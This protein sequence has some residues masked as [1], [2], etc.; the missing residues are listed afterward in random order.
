MAEKCLIY[1]ARKKLGATPGL[2]AVLI[3][4]SDYAN[5]SAPDEDPGDGLLAMQKLESSALSAWKVA[6]QL[7]ALDK[8][9][10]LLRPLKTVRLLIAPSPVEVAVEPKL[11]KSK[12]ETPTFEAIKAALK[13]WRDDVA[14]SQS[15]QAL[16]LFSG[17][18]LRRMVQDS[19]LLASD[20]LE[21]EDEELGKAFTLANVFNGMMPTGKFLEI[22]REQVYLVDACRDKPAQLDIMD[23]TNTPKIFGIRLNDD[24][25][26][27]RAAPIIFATMPGGSAAG[28]SGEPTYFAQSLLWALENGT[29]ELQQIDGPDGEVWPVSIDSLFD[30]MVRK[31]IVPDGA[32]VKSGL[33]KDFTAGFRRDAPTCSLAIKLRH[34]TL[35]PQIGKVSLKTELGD[36][37]FDFTKDEA[38]GIW[39]GEAVA[40]NY[41]LTVEALANEFQPMVVNARQF[42][43]VTPKIGFPW[44]HTLGDV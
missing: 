39:Y 2:H 18:G 4:V 19:I 17:H 12:T 5:L 35:I 16:F 20:F 42:N 3:G 7:K 21:D 9:Q 26:D 27:D 30:S 10:Q 11:G 32:L 23:D 43:P 40:G 33:A 8:N 14:Q 13:A 38:E 37:S 44:I 31:R 36:K 34:T 41:S 15:E 22:G 29:G 25:V 6:N 28:T 24:I 1:D